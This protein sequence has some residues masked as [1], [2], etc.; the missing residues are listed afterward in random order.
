MTTN[1]TRHNRFGLA[2]TISADVKRRVRRAC[3][4]GC[5]VCGCP[6][7]QYHHAGIAYANAATHDP[8]K[9]TLLC[10]GCHDRVTRGTYSDE[11]IEERMARPYCLEH[12]PA[13]ADVDYGSIAPHIR[14]AGT[15]FDNCT[16][17][18]RVHDYALLTMNKPK[19]TGA[20]AEISAM[21]ANTRGELSVVISRNQVLLMPHNWDVT[22][23][24]TRVRVWD[25]ARTPSL[26]LNL[27]PRSLIEIGQIE[28]HMLGW[29]ISGD[30]KTVR[31]TAPGARGPSTFGG[32]AMSNSRVG[33]QF[34][35]CRL[36]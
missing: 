20:P 11:L 34:G 19:E 7:I 27:V 6:F 28:S 24:G 1:T 32:G 3:G 22:M 2:R 5:V 14:F 10:G 9:I 31:V 13:M 12:G 15:D 8:T 29:N 30:T 18:V 25:E 36:R 16:M 17:P 26:T 23:E 21:F 4:F 33:Y 35:A